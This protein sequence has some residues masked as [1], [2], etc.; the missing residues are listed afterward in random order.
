MR[1]K[2]YHLCSIALAGLLCFAPATSVGAQSMFQSLFGNLFKSSPAKKKPAPMAP[3]APP[4]AGNSS[5]GNQAFSP[6]DR[7]RER[8]APRQYSSQGSYRTV[9]VRTCD[10][11]YFPISSS[12]SS[13]KFR[14]DAKVCSSRCGGGKLY[15]LPKRS[16]NVAAMVDLNGRRYDQLKTAFAY[17][18]KLVDGCAC[19]AMPWSAAERA[20]HNRYAY[21]E[22]IQRI[23]EKREERIRQQAILQQK[24]N[25][26]AKERAA[27]ALADA[28]AVR[29]SA[30]QTGEAS[31]NPQ[32]ANAPD[33][34]PAATLPAKIRQR[35]I[36]IALD[37][38]DGQVEAHALS[39]FYPQLPPVEVATTAPAIEKP[40]A[41]KKIRHAKKRRR[42]RKRTVKVKSAG[43]SFGGGGKYRWPGDR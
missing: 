17:R 12:A 15:Y 16:D 39:A 36:T 20:R 18:K 19:R 31:D 27:K 38:G 14:K 25:K 11:Y 34:N 35:G 42:S 29:S 24:L 9:C 7:D 37:G 5:Q 32:L 22:L 8:A 41:K 10:G 2:Y 13:R 26:A 6:T 4:S 40:K 1:T 33:E 43:W 21:A 3:L 28:N 30:D 23:N